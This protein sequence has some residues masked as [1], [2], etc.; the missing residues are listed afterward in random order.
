LFLKSAI[1]LSAV[2]ARGCNVR[3]IG[4]KCSQQLEDAAD[5]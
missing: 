3:R 4:D 1:R 5:K 2:V